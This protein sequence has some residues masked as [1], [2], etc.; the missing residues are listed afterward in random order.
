MNINIIKKGILRRE[1]HQPEESMM[2]ALQHPMTIII[3]GT[4]LEAF[5]VALPLDLV[6]LVILDDVPMMITTPGVRL[7]V[8]RL[9]NTAV[10]AREAEVRGPVL[11]LSLRNAIVP[12]HHHMVDVTMIDLQNILLLPVSLIVASDHAALPPDEGVLPLNVSVPNDR[13]LHALLAT[14]LLVS[15]ARMRAIEANLTKIVPPAWL[16]CR[17]MPIQCLTIDRNG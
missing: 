16:L 12:D 4:V 2:T 5:I 3:A 11:I 14:S 8:T 13:H 9:G 15:T 10:V 1:V 7:A 6:R 17:R